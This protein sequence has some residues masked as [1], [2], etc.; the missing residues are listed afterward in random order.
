MENFL[1][2]S[3]HLGFLALIILA[4]AAV[5]L[6]SPFSV[7]I[8]EGLEDIFLRAEGIEAEVYK[9]NF[10][11]PVLR[12]HLKGPGKLGPGV[13]IDG[14]YWIRNENTTEDDWPQCEDKFDEEYRTLSKSFGG[15]EDSETGIYC[16]ECTTKGTD[17]KED[18]PIVD[19]CNH[20]EYEVFVEDE[21][22]CA[23]GDETKYAERE[24][25]CSIEEDEKLVSSCEDLERL[26]G[27]D[28]HFYQVDNIDCEGHDFEP[29]ESF[30]GTFDGQGYE[31]KNMEASIGLFNKNKGTVKNLRLVNFN[32]SSVKRVGTVAQINKG[33]IFNTSVWGTATSSENSAGGLVRRNDGIISKS[34]STASVKGGYAAAGLA[35]DNYG[36]IYNS[37]ALGS[38]KGNEDFGAGGLVAHHHDHAKINKSYSAGR[39]FV[40]GSPQWLG[41]LVACKEGEVENSFWNI[42]IIDID[43]DEDSG[44]GTPKSEELMQNKKLYTNEASPDLEDAWNF[45]EVWVLDK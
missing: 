20:L 35:S 31:I 29:L 34:F 39:V 45:E 24:V 4:V 12:H 25:K 37:F 40:E 21:F 11:Y 33:K 7:D 30:S 41:G 13:G 1:K 3:T 22:A 15:Y 18:K 43:K 42:D 44:A 19:S 23:P 9:M 6:L 14:E 10:N 8:R 16:R 38:V 36:K 27:D 32:S 5:V 2:G 26:D 28:R 17:W